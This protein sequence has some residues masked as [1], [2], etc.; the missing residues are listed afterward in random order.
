MTSTFKFFTIALF[1]LATTNCYSQYYTGQKVFK[2]KF[3][4][5]TK[6][7]NQD[8]YIKI[9]N[10]SNDIIV[11]VENTYTGKVIQHA[12]ITSKD[13]YEFKYIPVGNYVCKYMW[14]DSN[15]KKHYEKDNSSMDFPKD[16]YGG[17]VITLTETPLGNLSQSGISES[18]FFD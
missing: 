4:P 14:T 7:Y 1:C 11:A 18:Q 16:Q 13:I 9:E 10:A 3:P 5:E 6:D 2:D 17:Y 8:T 15:G 12:Y